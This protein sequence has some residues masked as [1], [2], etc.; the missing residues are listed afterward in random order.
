MIQRQS[1]RKSGGNTD[2]EMKEE[3]SPVTKILKRSSSAASIPKNAKAKKETD[4]K[5]KTSSKV[6]KEEV[7]KAA[8]PKRVIDDEDEIQDNKL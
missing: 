1:S 7:K 4:S 8:K 6:V 3:T 5:D 2:V